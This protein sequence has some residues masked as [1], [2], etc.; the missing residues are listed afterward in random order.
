MCFI[1]WCYAALWVKQPKTAVIHTNATMSVNYKPCG[2]R[3]LLTWGTITKASATVAWNCSGI[4]KLCL[5]RLETTKFG[6]SHGNLGPNSEAKL[7]SHAIAQ[8]MSCFLATNQSQA[9]HAGLKVHNKSL[10]PLPRTG[11][12]AWALEPLKPV[13]P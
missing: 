7:K 9:E 11:L 8:C 6:N 1:R 2:K 13:S 3:D 4:V 12:S 10:P 5:D